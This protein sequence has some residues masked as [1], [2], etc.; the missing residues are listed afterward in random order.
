[1]RFTGI[2]LFLLLAT[3]A[4]KLARAADETE[5]TRF[6]VAIVTDGKPTNADVNNAYRMLSR[7]VMLPG[8]SRP[9]IYAINRGGTWTIDE[10]RAFSRFGGDFPNNVFFDKYAADPSTGV[11]AAIGHNGLF[12]IAPGEIK[13]RQIA[14]N[15]GQPLA[16]P[17]SIKF[18]GRWQRFVVAD[19]TGLFSWTPSLPLERLESKGP[20]NLLNPFLAIDLP[21]IGALL[22]SVQGSMAV[23]RFDDGRVEKLTDFGKDDFLVDAETSDDGQILIVRS[24]F[25][26]T[27]YS[28][29]PTG[30]F[31]ETLAQKGMRNTAANPFEPTDQRGDSR[32]L[33]APVSGHPLTYNRTG[34]FEMLPDGTKKPFSVPFDPV[35]TPV[36]DAME[37]PA[38]HALILFTSVAAFA[39]DAEGNVKELQSGTKLASVRL[40][41]ARGVIPGR[42]EM[43]VLGR[44]AL[45]L[46]IDKRLAGPRACLG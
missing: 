22:V 31:E 36:L 33:H 10:N 8:I 24:Y 37:M 45:Y 34:L 1:M 41:Q 4:G 46:I 35:A 18:I 5:N 44:D 14:S 42:N 38:S 2:G 32:T 21:K 30:I 26:T 40:P 7:V 9:I 13:F 12:T 17:Y 19:A 3:V 16:H 29:S 28:R 23:L 11:I 20:A 15:N 39:A 25:A 27:T 43:L 6:C